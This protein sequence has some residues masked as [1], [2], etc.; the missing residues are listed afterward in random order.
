MDNTDIYAI[1]LGAITATLA[2]RKVIHSVLLQLCPI[3]PRLAF[4]AAPPVQQIILRYMTFQTLIRQ[5]RFINRW[6]L[7]DI[8][9]LVFYLGSNIA[10]LCLPLPSV[11]DASRRAGRLAIINM[12]ALYAAPYFPFAADILGVSL[13]TFKRLH[14]SVS[15][16]SLI[17]VTFH[18]ILSAALNEIQ[19]PTAPLDL[20]ELIVRKL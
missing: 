4:W 7:L 3:I 13:A 14:S 5:R 10:C 12:G 1:V 8:L 11:T 20:F 15:Y 9:M 16:I 2:L 17:L 6:S 18:T 19:P